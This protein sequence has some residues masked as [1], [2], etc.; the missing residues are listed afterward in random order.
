[1]KNRDQNAGTGSRA[2]ATSRGA[3]SY[4]FIVKDRIDTRVL[5]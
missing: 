5:S 2:V 4:W 1:M 3:L